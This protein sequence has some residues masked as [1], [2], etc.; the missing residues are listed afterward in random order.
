VSK[1]GKAAALA[2]L[3]IAALATAC[4]GDDSDASSSPA[5]EAS[6]QT[7][8]C[9]ASKV[10]GELT[11]AVYSE[12]RGLDPVA[13]AGGGTAG[14]TEL[15]AL[16]DTL[17]RYDPETSTFEPWLAESLEPNDDFTEWTLTL[18]PDV[19]FGSG[20][21]VT[22]EAVEFSIA[23]HQD[24]ANG[25]SAYQDTLQITD[26]EVV[27]DLTLVF[28]LAEPWG[29]F[30]A[31]LADMPGMVIDPAVLDDVGPEAFTTDPVGAGAGPYEVSRFRP[32]EEIVFD[33]KDDYWGGPVC[34]ERLRFVDIPTEQATYDALE[35]GEVDVAF[36]R[37]PQIVAEADDAGFDRHGE[38]VH[39]GNFLMINSGLNDPVAA[40]PRIRQ[41]VA[42]AVD[43]AVV[44]DRVAGGDG[45]P[46]SSIVSDDSP[47]SPGIEGPAA[48]TAEAS[49]LV[50]EAKADGWDGTISL[51]CGDS[52]PDMGITVEAQLEAAGFDVE[53]QQVPTPDLVQRVFVDHNYELACSGAGVSEA[54]PAV[55]LERFFGTGNTL[56]GFSD[57]D[58]DEAL[59]SLKRASTPDEM[60]AAM[61]TVQEVWNDTVPSVSLSAVENVVAWSDRVHGLVFNENYSFYFARAYV[62][63]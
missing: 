43:Q 41:A 12:A 52:T 32:G 1:R 59:L 50:S 35:L 11:F 62:T 38:V 13:V 39:L 24:P 45:L 47:I 61:E 53:L 18:R 58:F 19:T 31:L 2:A 51:V 36:L 4:G 60:R 6:S 34:I 44:D 48:D 42:H 37:E 30:P 20:N 22:A 26:M 56:T 9:D 5:S 54:S 7:D 28:T 63:P 3:A 8:Y 10:G 27:D 17:M 33:A 16:Y 14:M 15:A 46:T 55:R 49:D 21:P 29:T 23:R 57:P 25:A 40:D